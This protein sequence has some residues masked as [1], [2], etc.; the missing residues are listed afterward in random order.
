MAWNPLDPAAVGPGKTRRLGSP[1]ARGVDGCR[2]RIARSPQFRLPTLILTLLLATIAGCDRPADA[3]AGE[4]GEGRLAA[5]HDAAALDRLGRTV[6]HALIDGDT[7]ALERIRITEYEHRE[8][9]WPEL[10]VGKPPSNFPVDIAWENIQVR[11]RAAVPHLIAY[12]RRA[13]VDLVRTECR[14]PTR[15]FE[16][17]H[18]LTGCVL[19]V[20]EA[21]GAMRDHRVFEEVVVLDGELRVVRY[22]AD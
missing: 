14:G 11:N 21:D 12:F 19:V 5:D 22:Y 20:R 4:A 8:V 15:R 17:F 3:R 16:R 2:R 1:R 9:I 10:P 18:V 6:L 7:A 13:P